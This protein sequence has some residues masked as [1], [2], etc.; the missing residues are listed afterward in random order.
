MFK[1][2]LKKEGKDVQETKLTE[3]RAMILG[4]QTVK[5]LGV[6]R[7]KNNGRLPEQI[8]IYR[9]GVGG[10]TMEPKIISMEV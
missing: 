4:D 5:A 6:Y 8:L 10:P 2:I 7:E 9:D 1:D 3:K